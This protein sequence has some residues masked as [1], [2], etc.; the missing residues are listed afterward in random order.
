MLFWWVTVALSLPTVFCACSEWT[1]L[2]EGCRIRVTLF[3][4]S[5]RKSL[6]ASEVAL[7]ANP[8]FCSDGEENALAR[9]IACNYPLAQILF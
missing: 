6:L 8:T 7:S 5:R 3:L 2:S 9:D 1:L 4:F